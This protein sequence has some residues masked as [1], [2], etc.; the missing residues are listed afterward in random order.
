MIDGNLKRYGTM[1]FLVLLMMF[2]TVLLAP[3]RASSEID[4]SQN[5]SILEEG[6]SI[7]GP[8]FFAGNFV[9]VDGNV[10]GTTF[11]S[12][13]DVQINGV[14]HGDLFVA[15][16]TVTINGKVDGNIYG[17]AQN[18]KVGTESTADVFAAAQTIE[19]VKEAII[20]RDLFTVGQTINMNGTV[21]RQF[22]GGGSDI[23]ISG[24]IG[25][26]AN[27]D[28]SNITLL[29]GTVIK[30]DFLYRSIKQATIDPGTTITGETD[31]SQATP[32][33]EQ[34]KQKPYS[35]V[36]SILLKIAGAMIIWL[37]IRL[38]W[39]SFWERIA[40]TVKEQPLKTIGMGALIFILTPIAII[41]MMITVIGIP[42]GIITGFVYGATLYLS[43]IVVAAF[44]AAMLAERFGWAKQGKGVWAVLLC[45][46]LLILLFEVPMLGAAA[47]LVTAFTGLGSLLLYKRSSPA[48]K[49]DSVTFNTP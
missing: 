24:N 49:S 47:W 12:G 45:L 42:L 37:I 44:G 27:L 40:R 39:P 9:R 2:L 13:Q 4:N 35:E 26:D 29:D 46:A 20:G 15:A 6:E 8:G 3:V 11:A 18:M 23:L 38:L 48:P 17:A 41:L 32:V 21:K 16:Q 28:A 34:P 5:M 30:G 31:W 1:I 7:D 33:T 10:E 36:V 22:F 25:G 43:K 19:L 14:I